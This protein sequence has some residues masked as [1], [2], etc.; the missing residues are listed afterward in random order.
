[1]SVWRRQLKR[2]GTGAVALDAV[3]REMP[4]L[5]EVFSIG[6]DLVGIVEVVRQFESERLG[7]VRN[8]D[9]EPIPG[10]AY[11]VGKALSRPSFQVLGGAV[12]GIDLS[13]R[14]VQVHGRPGAVVERWASP[15]QRVAAARAVAGGEL[16]GAREHRVRL[17]DA[18]LGARSRNGGGLSERKRTQQYQERE[19][20]P[21]RAGHSWQTS[22]AE[23]RT[24]SWAGGWRCRGSQ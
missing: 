8:V 6:E 18:D 16:P 19:Q 17:P 3:G 22:T 11:E 7:R 5:A 10:E 2:D 20:D 21:M 12:S 23:L 14:R 4:E 13:G 9:S 24:G 1:V 15:E